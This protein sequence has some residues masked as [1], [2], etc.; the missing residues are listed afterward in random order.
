[1]DLIFCLLNTHYAYSKEEYVYGFSI[2]MPLK[3]AAPR[4][5]NNCEVVFYHFF[6]LVMDG[7]ILGLF[8]CLAASILN[9]KLTEQ[10]T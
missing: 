1:M 9:M 4:H 6:A 7:V 2:T 10:F 8:V 5:K 3:I